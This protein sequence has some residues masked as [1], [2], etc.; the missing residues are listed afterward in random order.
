M[1]ESL[2]KKQ[3]KFIYIDLLLHNEVQETILVDKKFYAP[4]NNWHIERRGHSYFLIENYMEGILVQDVEEVY[5]VGNW[6]YH[7]Y[8]DERKSG[9]Y[10]S[11]SDMFSFSYW[12]Y[13]SIIYFFAFL[14]IAWIQSLPY[15]D[16]S[17]IAIGSGMG[18]GEKERS[19]IITFI[20]QQAVN[21][22]RSKSKKNPS[23]DYQPVDSKEDARPLEIGDRY[24]E[25]TL[26][27]GD[28]R[29]STQKF[30]NTHS[31]E[32]HPIWAE[33]GHGDEVEPKF[34]KD[35]DIENDKLTAIERA[36]AH[37]EVES[38]FAE[39]EE[40]EPI[41]AKKYFE[42]TYNI[43]KHAY[44]H[45]CRRYRI[46]E[47]IP[48][49]SRNKMENRIRKIAKSK[50]SS[51]EIHF[52]IDTNKTITSLEVFGINDRDAFGLKRDLQWMINMT[53]PYPKS[54]GYE[55]IMKLDFSEFS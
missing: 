27:I 22:F 1:K 48:T 42:N 2:K 50:R 35:A 38:L 13:I 4:G 7:I 20:R 19:S 41:T 10:F 8:W 31:K 51:L 46:S 45:D 44:L 15:P 23:K 32:K 24:E 29:S 43:K 18:L 11:I 16:T 54:C 26:K 36:I 21:L 28:G 9:D 30:K 47:Y 3:H 53:L 25:R 12:S 33:T 40:P 14:G 52:F 55:I 5:E 17:Q 34:S 37:A 49:A 39:R 6:K